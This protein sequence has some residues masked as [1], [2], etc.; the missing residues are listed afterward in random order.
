MARPAWIRRHDPP[1]REVHGLADAGARRLQ[2]A[3]QR[4]KAHLRARTALPDDAGL[5][6]RRVEGGRRTWWHRSEIQLAGWSPASARIR[7]AGANR[8]NDAVTRRHRR[9]AEDVEVLRELH[10]HYRIA[11]RNLWQGDVDL[12]PAHVALLRTAHGRHHRRDRSDAA[13]SGGWRGESDAV[14]ER[15]SATDCLGFPRC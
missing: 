14:Q 3:L 7:A 4:R 12:R 13:T 8:T 15:T 2:Q 6:L 11:K 5:R 10:R 1:H 9:R